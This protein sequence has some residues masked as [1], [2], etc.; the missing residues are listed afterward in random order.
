[1]YSIRI[2]DPNNL[3]IINIILQIF[4]DQIGNGVLYN[5]HRGSNVNFESFIT[6]L[7]VRRDDLSNIRL[8]LKQITFQNI[9]STFLCLSDVLSCSC[10]HSF[11]PH[12]SFQQMM[13]SLSPPNWL[14]PP[15]LPHRPYTPQA[16]LPLPAN[17]D[18]TINSPIG[19]PQCPPE[20]NIVE[21]K[22][23]IFFF[24][25]SWVDTISRLLSSQNRNSSFQRVSQFLCKILQYFAKLSL[26][27]IC[28]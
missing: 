4:W 3:Y 14:V 23:N 27:N 12:F 1:M 10:S 18:Q 24:G 7:K 2:Q 11:S 28:P 20:R 9:I 17:N 6:L 8:L 25:V 13:T 5:L 21:K 15:P 16:P 22:V 19:R 26:Y